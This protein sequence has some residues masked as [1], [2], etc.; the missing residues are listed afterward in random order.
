MYRVLIATPLLCMIPQMI[1]NAL[2]TK[3]KVD[4]F[5]NLAVKQNDEST[6]GAT[7][8]RASTTASGSVN[9][10]SETREPS[11]RSILSDASAP[12]RTLHIIVVSCQLNLHGRRRILFAS[13]FLGPLHVAA[14]YVPKL[15]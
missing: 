14:M 11:M 5:E 12:R 7:Q 3:K 4:L 2:M 15:F 10:I 9:R 13:H 6:H 1:R 8:V